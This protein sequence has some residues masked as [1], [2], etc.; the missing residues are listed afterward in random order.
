MQ[1][2]MNQ[3]I[4]II[5]IILLLT[6][7]VM[8]ILVFFLYASHQAVL[9]TASVKSS[10]EMHTPFEIQIQPFNVTDEKTH[11]INALEESG[12]Y[13]RYNY[14]FD[15]R[16]HQA[17]LES[18]LRFSDLK[19][20]ILS[21]QDV[22]VRKSWKYERFMYKGKP[23]LKAWIHGNNLKLYFNLDPKL[24]EDSKYSIEDVSYGKM[25]EHTPALFT[26]N[27][28][29][30]LEYAKELVEFILK[31]VKKQEQSTVD[32]TVRYIER[33]QLIQMKLVK[34]NRR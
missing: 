30:L 31:D 29:R 28:P 13:I 4:N 21:Y 27:G 23:I 32:Y 24:F 26:V 33:D 34:I 19:N 2:W 14:S 6:I 25:H 7:L 3:N 20:Y 15:A 1:Q 16:M 18:Q 8:A 9:K 22:E 12:L 17:P 11:Q 5:V 10:N